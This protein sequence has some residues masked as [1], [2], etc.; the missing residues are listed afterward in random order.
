MEA[1]AFN[2][3]ARY[4]HGVQI[5]LATD[6]SSQP[7]GSRWVIQLFGKEGKNQ[8]TRE[9]IIPR[10]A[11][12]AL[13]ANLA[14]LVRGSGRCFLTQSLRQT[15]SL[16]GGGGECVTPPEP[17]RA[18]TSMLIGHS[19]RGEDRRNR[20]SLHVE[21]GTYALDEVVSSW[22]MQLMISRMWLTWYQRVSLFAVTASGGPFHPADHAGI[23]QYGFE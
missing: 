3:K 18:S 4:R 10:S 19:Y 1:F 23:W 21:D 15:L 2:I 8:E 13:P 12:A 5:Y 17:V 16:G 9:P 14:G 6:S 11:L 22:R 7:T 20:D